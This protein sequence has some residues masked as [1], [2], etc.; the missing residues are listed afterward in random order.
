MKK[1]ISNLHPS[2]DAACALRP[3]LAETVRPSPAHMPMLA[4]IF[5]TCDW[6]MRVIMACGAMRM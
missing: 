4:H 6:A 2:D 5:F 1:S 3:L